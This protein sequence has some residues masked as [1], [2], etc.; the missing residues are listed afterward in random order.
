MPIPSPRLGDIF[1]LF[2]TFPFDFDRSLPINAGP[3][4]CLDSTPQ[5]LLDN[6][7]PRGLADYVLPGYTFDGGLVHCC[8]RKPVS[9]VLPE[10][11]TVR[12][13]LFLSITG[14]RLVAHMGSES[15][16]SLNLKEGL[17]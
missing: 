12:Q 8:L 2:H 7:D 11:M 9:I 17:V 14:F 15:A 5:H 10:N 4:V 13:A 6:A 3:G 16:G 1:L